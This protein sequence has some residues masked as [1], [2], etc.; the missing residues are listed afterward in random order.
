[1]DGWMDLLQY[2]FSST[3]FGPP[4]HFTGAASGWR[5]A[6]SQPLFKSVRECVWTLTAKNSTLTQRR[7][8]ELVVGFFEQAFCWAWKQK[9]TAVKTKPLNRAFTLSNGPNANYKS[10]ARNCVFLCLPTGSE[11]SVMMTSKASW[12]FFMNSK[13]SPT[14]RVSLGL[15][16]PFAIPGRYFFETLMTSCFKIHR[17]N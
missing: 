7:F 3:R 8:H 5:F 6:S 4:I 11:E 17:K 12:F 1:M 13:P 15:K 16:N 9:H 2:F 10:R 14:F